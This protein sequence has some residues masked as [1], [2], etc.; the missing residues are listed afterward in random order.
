V[1]NPEKIAMAVSLPLYLIILLLTPITF[2]FGRIKKVMLLWGDKNP[3]HEHP[4]VTEEELKYIIDEIREE[5]VLEN[6]ESKLVRSAL[7]LDEI[8]A[9][10]AL[11]PRV[12]VI[13]A[14]VNADIESIKN[15]F[16]TE[17]YS[18]MPVYENNLD[19]ILG[20]I[21]QKDFFR[22]VLENKTDIRDII[23][24]VQYV[25][26]L[27]PVSQV[28]VEMQRTNT[29]MVIVK[30]QHGG[31]KGL[32]T[33]ED[34]MEELFGEIYDEDDEIIVKIQKKSDKEYEVSGDLELDELLET[35]GLDEDAVPSIGNTVGGFVTE[36][37]G[38]I[39]E[40]NEELVYEDLFN[41][42]VLSIADNTVRKVYLTLLS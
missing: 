24:K 36:L 6:E 28:L 29:H 18:R 31:T 4:S 11:V 30:D 10:K 39:P 2:F 21:T 12:N 17:M 3:E 19:N 20:I 13:G 1:L 8:T 41:I 15:L 22:F 34:I 35:L 16:L 27:M 37:A 25:S 23:Q 9:D 32:I 14:E 26:E 7:D 42:R 5:G 40:E 38:H 33:M